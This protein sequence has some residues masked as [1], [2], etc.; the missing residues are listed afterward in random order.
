[1]LGA[2]GPDRL[3][4][5]KAD[6]GGLMLGRQDFAESSLSVALAQPQ[7]IGGSARQLAC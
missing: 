4:D 1:M 2:D 3:P 7:D 6:T 5:P